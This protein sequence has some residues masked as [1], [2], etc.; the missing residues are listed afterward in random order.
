[1]GSTFSHSATSPL[2]LYCATSSVVTLQSS[3]TSPRLQ[4]RGHNS[5]DPKA[6]RRDG[7]NYFVFVETL[8]FIGI[9]P[10]VAEDFRGMFS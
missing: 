10:Q 5:T 4:N 2:K 3:A 1:M 7:L 9:E 8:D 6:S